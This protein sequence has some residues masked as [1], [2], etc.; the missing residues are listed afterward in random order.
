[1]EDK[2][3]IW[4]RKPVDKN[5]FFE[6]FNE[7]EDKI[8]RKIMEQKYFSDNWKDYYIFPIDFPIH[9]DWNDTT[10]V[11]C[12]DIKTMIDEFIE[13]A[14]KKFGEYSILKKEIKT[15]TIFI[16]EYRD[17]NMNRLSFDEWQE[18]LEIDFYDDEMQEMFEIFENEL[19]EKL[20]NDLSYNDIFRKERKTLEQIEEILKEYLRVKKA[21]YLFENCEGGI[22]KYDYIFDYNDGAIKFHKDYLD[23]C[24]NFLM[25][26]TVQKVYKNYLKLFELIRKQIKNYYKVEK[27]LEKLKA[28]EII[29]KEIRE[30]EKRLEG[31]ENFEMFE[32]RFYLPKV[33]VFDLLE[34]IISLDEVV[35][36]FETDYDIFFEDYLEPVISMFYDKVVYGDE[37]DDYDYEEKYFGYEEDDEVEIY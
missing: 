1:M 13:Y 3:G 30:F 36:E 34:K 18:F 14:Q 6:F 28:S 25:S 2:F 35:F 27:E 37:D 5:I 9:Y 11:D 12:L 32:R 7:Y 22:F 16:K 20:E 23:T 17:K 26:E 8:S 31:E 4:E 24:H 19:E 33:F 15:P 10:A 21:N 29:A